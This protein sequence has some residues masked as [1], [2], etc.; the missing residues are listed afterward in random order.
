[1]YICIAAGVVLTRPNTAESLK[2]AKTDSEIVESENFAVVEH[3]QENDEEE[4]TDEGDEEQKD[5]EIEALRREHIEALEEL[6][7]ARL[8]LSEGNLAQ[9]AAAAAADAAAAAAAD[10]AALRKEATE[11]AGELLGICLAPALEAE[12][13]D[14]ARAE[15]RVESLAAAQA[16]LETF[17]HPVLAREAA[18]ILS[19]FAKCRL[20]VAEALN[21]TTQLA[22]DVA[23]QRRINPPPQAYPQGVKPCDSIPSSS[24]E[25]DEATLSSLAVSPNRHDSAEFSEIK[26]Q[27]DLRATRSLAWGAPSEECQPNETVYGSAA[28]VALEHLISQE[29]EWLK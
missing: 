1:V 28:A 19:T 7:I 6:E 24:L 27:V 22:Q 21:I 3:E 14:I 25:G 26:K 23:R 20:L 4:E 11:E 13:R 29:R 12:A 5:E 10:A 18:A 16:M 8:Q 17:L 2:T 9:A 15:L